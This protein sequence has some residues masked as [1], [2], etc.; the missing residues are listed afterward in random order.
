MLWKVH[1]KSDKNGD[2]KT[3]SVW[4]SKIPICETKNARVL[5]RFHRHVFQKKSLRIFSDTC[6]QSD[7]L[8]MA[9]FS[10]IIGFSGQKGSER[11]GKQEKKG[12][13][14]GNEQLL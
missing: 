14:S 8:C 11:I 13:F 6:R 7:S 2:K 9:F 4:N 1:S 12:R 5:L 10:R 3:L